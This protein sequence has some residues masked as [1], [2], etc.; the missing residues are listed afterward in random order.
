MNYQK[1]RRLHS[2][3]FLR[4]PELISKLIRNSSI[5]K[6]DLVI[7]IGPGKGSITG[8]L[9]KVAGKVI[10][11]EIDEKLTLHLLKRFKNYRNLEFYYSDFLKFNLPNHPFKVFAN[12]PFNI[13]ADIVRKLTDSMNFTEGYLVVQ[14]EFAKKIIGKPVDNKNSMMSFL[15]KPWFDITIYHKFARTD[16]VPFPH[17]DS[18]MVRIT[19][20][21]NLQIP[22]FQKEKYRDFILYTYNRQNIVREDFS[23]ILNRFND[24]L[25]NESDYEKERV[26][27]KALEIIKDQNSIQKIH[28]TRNDKNW[29]K[30]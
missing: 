15:L 14:T 9:V 17:V 1:R 30:F 21:I 23:Q 5:G 25:N 13:S 4:N 20:K 29:R 7:E 10:G 22:Y 24:Y 18:V 3:N 16:F 8:E 12:I 11:V 27:M 2:Q 6:N 26:H 19:R 28:R